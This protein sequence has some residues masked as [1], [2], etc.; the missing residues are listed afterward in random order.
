M[1]VVDISQFHVHILLTLLYITALKVR[2]DK[3]FGSGHFSSV[4][5]AWVVRCEV[6]VLRAVLLKLWD[7]NWMSDVGN[8]GID[9]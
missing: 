3:Y 9:L 6:T 4:S 8:Q 5:E 1:T 2:L 7:W